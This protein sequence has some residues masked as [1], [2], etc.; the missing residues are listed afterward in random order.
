MPKTLLLGLDS[1]EIFERDL[2]IF[3]DT[4]FM[5]EQAT[6]KPKNVWLLKPDDLNRG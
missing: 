4:F 1:A 5:T 6:P 3:V 2:K